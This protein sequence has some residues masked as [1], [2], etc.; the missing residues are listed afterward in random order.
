MNQPAPAAGKRHPV[1]CDMS[2]APDTPAERL[3]EYRRLFD[4]FLLG[5]ERSAAGR[6]PAEGLAATCNRGS[7]LAMC[8][9][10]PRM[11]GLARTR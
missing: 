6:T 9:A 8:N 7:M 2:G 11:P 10:T 4:G 5:R 3:E 1:A